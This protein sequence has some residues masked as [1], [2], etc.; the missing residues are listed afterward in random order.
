M[1]GPEAEWFSFDERENEFR[2]ASI[3]GFTCPNITAILEHD[4]E[5]W[6]DENSGYSIGGKFGDK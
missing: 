3:D 5:Y 1:E 4:E 2:S 6:D